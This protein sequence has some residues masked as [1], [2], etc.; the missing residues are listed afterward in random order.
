MIGREFY[1][2]FCGGPFHSVPL[3]QQR[4]H[5]GRP[6]FDYYNADIL[7]PDDFDWLYDLRV[8]GENPDASGVS[9]AYFSG[10]GIM[11]NSGGARVTRGPDPNAFGADAH[12][13]ECYSRLVSDRRPVYPHHAACGGVLAYA[14][15]GTPDTTSLDKGILFDVIY[16][17]ICGDRL[18]YNRLDLEYDEPGTDIVCPSWEEWEVQ[19]GDEL[20]VVSPGWSTTL[21]NYRPMGTD[22]TLSGLPRDIL[23]LILRLLDHD[24]L[25]NL[26]QASRNIKPFYDQACARALEAAPPAVN[27]AI[28]SQTLSFHM[29][30]LSIA[31]EPDPI[32]THTYWLYSWDELRASKTL[33]TFWDVAGILVG[34][35]LGPRRHKRRVVGKDDAEDEIMVRSVEIDGGDWVTGFIFHIPVWNQLEQKRN[36]VEI[37]VKSVLATAPKGI[38]VQFSGGNRIQIGD[39]NPSLCQRPMLA[40]SGMR[41]VG[42]SSLLGTYQD[43]YRFHRFGLLQAPFPPSEETFVRTKLPSPPVFE[44]CL[45]KGE[46]CRPLGRPIWEWQEWR[47]LQPLSMTGQV[48]TLWDSCDWWL[49]GREHEVFMW[50]HDQDELS[51]LSAIS[52]DVSICGEPCEHGEASGG[53]RNLKAEYGGGL[54]SRLVRSTEVD[55]SLMSDEMR[56]RFTIN[57]SGGERVEE[58]GFVKY[59][60]HGLRLRTNWNREVTWGGCSKSGWWETV[61]VPD[62][63]VVAGLVLVFRDVGKTNKDIHNNR[64][65]GGNTPDHLSVEQT[66]VNSDDSGAKYEFCTILDEVGVLTLPE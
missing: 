61:R 27:E 1:C 6:S 33:E 44:R 35:A 16:F 4:V 22:D 25:I 11:T 65:S 17:V 45:W 12:E 10:R 5:Q 18:Q 51:Q 54:R 38:T 37:W 64:D 42:G 43:E 23:Y 30:R 15:S 19:F 56:E 40:N 50:A 36:P 57:G 59:T 9:K 32:A 62:G 34:I 53:I 39:T 63:R 66:E 46:S 14:L 21:T 7:S 47:D 58:I 41:I 60:C 55:G 20:L 31:E 2:A 3:A 48:D 52:A 24:S 29:P 28:R 26:L 49:V 13:L 8:L